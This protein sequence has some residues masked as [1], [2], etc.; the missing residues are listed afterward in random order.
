MRPARDVGRGAAGGSEADGDGAREERAVD[1][2]DQAAVPLPAP[3]HPGLLGHWGPFLTLVAV[4]NASRN[5]E[6]TNSLVSTK[7]GWQ[8]SLFFF[9]VLMAKAENRVVG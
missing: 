3:S 8:Q 5:A 4:T 6:Q 2:R 7:T 1:Q 9:E